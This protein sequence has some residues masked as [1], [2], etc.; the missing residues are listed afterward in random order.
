METMVIRM[1]R[2]LVFTLAAMMLFGT[3][4]A[5][6]AE[7]Y[8]ATYDYIYYDANDWYDYDE[9]YDEWSATEPAANSDPTYM[10]WGTQVDENGNLLSD[11]WYLLTEN[12]YDANSYLYFVPTEFSISSAGASVYIVDQGQE[13]AAGEIC[14]L[15]DDLH[16]VPDAYGTIGF[17]FVMCDPYNIYDYSTGFWYSR[18]D[19]QAIC[20]EFINRTYNYEGYDEGITFYEDG[21]YCEVY[22]GVEYYGIWWVSANAEIRW[23][24]D[25]AT[26][27][28]YAYI[29]FTEDGHVECIGGSGYLYPIN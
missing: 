15:T 2:K 29:Y 5:V 23:M 13:L 26:D 20:N 6:S 9:L 12:G 4:A 7:S 3:N 14:V 8:D 21:T 28:T 19:Y 25:G 22:E 10:T 18:G 27:P 1:K 11:V 16:M 17:D 24:Q